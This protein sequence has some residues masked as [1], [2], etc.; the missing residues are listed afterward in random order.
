MDPADAS[1]DQALLTQADSAFD[2][3]MSHLQESFFGPAAECFETARALY[4]QVPNSLHGEAVS[5]RNL[6]LALAN[7]GKNAAAERALQ[8]AFIGYGQLDGTSGDLAACFEILAGVH[9]RE[10]RLREAVDALQQAIAAYEKVRG[11]EHRRYRC[12]TELGRLLEDHGHFLAAAGAYDRGLALCRL[13]E[14][15]ELEQAQCLHDI[16]FALRFSGLLSSAASALEN[17]LK[18]CRDLDTAQYLRATILLVLGSVRL[19]SGRIS[20]AAVVYQEALD[21]FQHVE[22]SEAHQAD[23]RVN[24]GIAYAHGGRLHDAEHEVLRALEQYEMLDG[25]AADQAKCL[26]NISSFQL[27]TGRMAAAR[28]SILRAIDLYDSSEG[29][30][31]ERAVSLMN[32]GLIHM[33]ERRFASAIEAIRGALDLHSTLEHSERSR[34]DCHTNLATSFLGMGNAFL[35]EIEYAHALRLFTQLGLEHESRKVE[36]NLALLREH[37]SQVSSGPKAQQ[38]LREAVALAARSAVDV[39]RSRVQFRTERERDAW[40][41][42]VGAP[43]IETAF[44]LAA[45]TGDAVLI[46]DLIALGRAAGILEIMRDVKG[47]RLA[48]GVPVPAIDPAS[49]SLTQSSAPAREALPSLTAGATATTALGLDT[50]FRRRPLPALLMPGGRIALAEHSDPGDGPRPVIRYG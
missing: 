37:Q 32:L 27:T 16:G 47:S 1:S 21:A 38:L 7:L 33:R 26:I 15:T 19:D 35:A 49:S 43:R 2:I 39:E 36:H 34:A 10:N 30:V 24:L 46:A 8:R 17:A 22:G 50:L 29:H 3:G 44:R 5:S 23:C 4:A 31:R 28:N 12:F 45:R 41:H 25:T 48:A 11:T 13:F 42:E 18:L 14:G 40:I 20:D 6:A 9:K